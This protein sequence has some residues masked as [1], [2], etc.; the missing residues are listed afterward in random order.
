[1][2]TL[3]RLDIVISANSTEAARGMGATTRGLEGVERAAMRT[4]RRMISLGGAF[5]AAVV[6]GVARLLGGMAKAVFDLGASVE[7]TQSKFDVTFAQASAGMQDFLDTF[8]H[9]AGITNREAQDLVATTAAIAQGMGFAIDESAQYAQQVTRLAA[10]ISSFNNVA[11]G[12]AGVIGAINA[13]VAGERERLK[14]WGI[15]IL[16]AD[17]KM[18]ALTDTGKRHESQLTQQDKAMATLAIITER[19]GVAVGDLDRTQ[20]SAANTARR[21]FARLRELREE[22]ATA[23]LPIMAQLLGAMDDNRE[24]MDQLSEAI[25][26]I[27]RFISTGIAVVQLFGVEMAVL[28]AKAELGWA[29]VKHAAADAMLNSGIAGYVQRLS[30]FFYDL[31]P[32]LQGILGIPGPV[33]PVGMV[34][35]LA[36]LLEEDTA[37]GVQRAQ[38]NFNNIV[39]AAE[40][41]REEVLRNLNDALQQQGAGSRMQRDDPDLPDTITDAQRLAEIVARIEADLRGIAAM[42]ELATPLE[43]MKERAAV[44]ERGI[45][46]VAEAGLENSV[47]TAAW[48]E[49]LALLQ[50]QIANLENLAA[51]EE[52]L[53]RQAEDAAKAHTM[54]HDAARGFID[55]FAE[56]LSR[57]TSEGKAAFK[58]FA[59]AVIAE[60]N[61]IAIK[62]AIIEVVKAFFPGNTTLLGLVGAAPQPRATGGLLT[63]GRPVKLHR[64]EVVVP[65]APAVAIPATVAARGGGMGG[66]MVVHVSQHFN[67]SAMDGPSVRRVLE[68]ERGTIARFV[69]EAVENSGGYRRQLFYGG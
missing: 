49:Q 57:F 32:W 55:D 28:G 34:H 5:K 1:M 39:R 38:N 24:V 41:M 17:V 63:P 26:S 69:A 47:A 40:E 52:I 58:G 36:A 60:L 29:K 35:G 25:R 2:A 22:L 10:D 30:D 46:A 4:E 27:A 12:S 64:D 6:I 11:E 9:K 51:V 14:Q 20:N 21:V 23:V 65:V 53:R 13:A 62:M 61:R 7:E 45:R 18:R 66:G 31:P 19:A 42:E 37:T 16:D 67:I 50:G 15:Q 33:N 43:L 68:Q 54:L 48:V 3:A 44:L 56:R 59:D 8:A